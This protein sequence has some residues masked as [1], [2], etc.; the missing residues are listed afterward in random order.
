MAQS[1]D[2]FDTVLGA[3]AT[4]DTEADEIEKLIEMTKGG[5]DTVISATTNNWARSILP[6]RLCGGEAV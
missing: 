3:D 1:N 4:F 2:E 5:V 6:S